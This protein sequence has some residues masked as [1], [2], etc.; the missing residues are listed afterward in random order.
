MS[1][2]LRDE[3]SI[4]VEGKL[5]ELV[6]FTANAVL[7]ERYQRGQWQV[8][9]RTDRKCVMAAFVGEARRM[10]KRAVAARKMAFSYLD[11][12]E[13]LVNDAQTISQPS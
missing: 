10:L 11:A 1:W 9:E 4:G 8:H 5:L 7:S 3:K 2:T 13:E 12:A 6:A